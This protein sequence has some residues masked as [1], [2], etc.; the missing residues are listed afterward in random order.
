MKRLFYFLS[1]SL[2]LFYFNSFAQSDYTIGN[3]NFTDPSIWYSGSVPTGSATISGGTAVTLTSAYSLDD[4]IV[5][6]PNASF[7]MTNQ[8]PL[9]LSNFVN[10][11]NFY[12]GNGSIYFNNYNYPYI[13]GIPT[14]FYN[15]YVSNGDVPF[16]NVVTVT[17]KLDLSGGS[18]WLDEGSSLYMGPG[19]TVTAT[20]GFDNN[21]CVI[22]RASD[23]T[24]GYLGRYAQSTNDKL[25]FPVGT[26]VD[27]NKQYSPIMIEYTSSNI[28]NDAHF[29]VSPVAQ[30]H[31]ENTS[32]GSYIN[33]YWEVYYQG[34]T[35]FGVVV[36]CYYNSSDVVGNEA[37]L[38][39][40]KK[41]WGMD[42]ERLGPVDPETHSFSGS[43]DGFSDFTAGEYDVMPVELTSFTVLYDGE[44]N[45]LS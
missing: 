4:E 31:P 17:N 11:G 26:I 7:W 35:G 20:T 39:G 15:V 22:P 8:A 24:Y 18:A 16:Y 9:T 1:C 23:A 38:W 10:E 33:R 32:S 42:W 3:G 40:G 36:T 5:I 27:G 2:F 25:L 37:D 21:H 45:L 28:T 34:F 44:A 29:V 13:S 41:D 12:P 43:V 6:E 30:K 14:S 19:A